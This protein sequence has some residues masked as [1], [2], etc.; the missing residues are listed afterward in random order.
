ML[1]SQCYQGAQKFFKAWWFCCWARGF[2]P[3]LAWWA[4]KNLWDKFVKK[5]KLK[6][7]CKRYNYC[8]KLFIQFC[9]DFKIMLVRNFLAT[10][11]NDFWG[12]TLLIVIGLQGQACKFGFLCT[13]AAVRGKVKWL[14]VDDV[15]LYFFQ[16]VCASVMIFACQTKVR[17]Y[18]SQ[19]IFLSRFYNVGLDM[20][21]WWSVWPFKWKLLTSTFMWHYY[22][23]Q[24]YIYLFM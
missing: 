15:L 7:Y 24:I 22:L 2:P 3:L 4:S 17:L 5:F 13:R 12:R 14:Q 1:T 23:F 18:A 6:M 16:L 20:K 10:S 8:I 9:I 11:V 21:P 19:I